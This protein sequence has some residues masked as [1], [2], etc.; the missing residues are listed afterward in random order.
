MEL[1]TCKEG[2]GAREEV[3]EVGRSLI[4]YGVL[5]LVYK[6]QQKKPLGLFCFFFF[7]EAVHHLIY[8]LKGHFDSPLENE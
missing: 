6:Q 5:P 3:G 7:S 1:S 4:T 8:I 2:K